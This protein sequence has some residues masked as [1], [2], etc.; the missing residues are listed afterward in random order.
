MSYTILVVEDERP[1]LGAIQAKLEQE[2]FEVVTARTVEQALDY[3]DE[4]VPVDAIWLD[5]YLLGKETGLDFVATLKGEGGAHRHIPVFVVSNTA[6]PDKKQTYL[7][8][9]VSKFYVKANHPLTEIV[10]AIKNHLTNHA[11]K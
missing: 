2:S 8:L 1:L 11:P 9:G 5:H 10:D 7:E 6:T 4:G 3:I